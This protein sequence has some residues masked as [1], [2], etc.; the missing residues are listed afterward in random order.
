MDTSEREVVVGSPSTG[1]PKWSRP[2]TLEEK[3]LMRNKR[4]KLRRKKGRIVNS[5]RKRMDG[6]Q[7]V[8]KCERSMRELSESKGLL[9]KVELG[10]SK[11]KEA[12]VSEMMAYQAQH[13]SPQRL[14]SHAFH[15][16]DP[17][18]LLDPEVITDS[19][20][21]QIGRGSW[22]NCQII[23]IQRHYVA[24]KQLLPKTLLTDVIMK[25]YL[26]CRSIGHTGV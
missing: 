8:I 2:N 26:I 15:E 13:C 21:L 24:V 17:S 18:N 16:I 20:D 25:L 12:M 11:T 4:R 7:Q 10:T 19:M 1:V 23:G 6:L 14:V 22:R 9:G 3:R 5:Y